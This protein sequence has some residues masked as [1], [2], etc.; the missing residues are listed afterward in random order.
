MA[1]EL[2]DHGFRVVAGLLA[3]GLALL[4]LL[5]AAWSGRARREVFLPLALTVAFLLPVLLVDSTSTYVPSDAHNFLSD[6]TGNGG[7]ELST[8]ADPSQL[9]WPQWLPLPSIDKLDLQWPNFSADPRFMLAI[10]AEEWNEKGC[11]TCADADDIGHAY[12]MAFE[13]VSYKMNGRLML[14]TAW[15]RSPIDVHC[16]VCG[17]RVQALRPTKK[18]C[19]NACRLRLSRWQRLPS[20]VKR[21]RTAKLAKQWRRAQ[22]TKE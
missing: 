19:S 8:T 6:F 9:G 17:R 4:G 3:L 10:A 11:N 16:L 22:W 12:R 18:T 20:K 15:K 7:V 1:D 2:V 13:Y 5:A 21:R 14:P